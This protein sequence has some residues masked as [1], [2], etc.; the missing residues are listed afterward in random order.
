M[1]SSPDYDKC[2]TAFD[3]HGVKIT[4]ENSGKLA[5]IFNDAIKRSRSGQSVLFKLSYRQK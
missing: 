3:G 4:R 5:D 2:V 1:I